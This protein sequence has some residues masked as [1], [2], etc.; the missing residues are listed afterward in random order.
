MPA[1][2]NNASQKAAGLYVAFFNRKPDASG[3]E[4]WS[5]KFGEGTGVEEAADRFADSEE[6]QA[7][8]EFLSEHLNGDD[9][10]FSEE[11]AGD[12]IDQIYQNLFGRDPDD[13]GREFWINELQSGTPVGQIV[14]QV[15][16]GAQ[17]EDADLID[18][19]VETRLQAVEG[20]RNA[21]IT[22]E[23]DNGDNT[24][25]GTDRDDELSGGAG[26]D[27]LRGGAG[28]DTL[29]GGVGDDVLNGGPGDD[30]LTGGA[31]ADDFVFD[32]AETDD[33]DATGDDSDSDADDE[34]GDE[35]GTDTSDAMGPP[36]GKGPPSNA[37]PN[38][39]DGGAED[40]EG[41]GDV[42]QAGNGPDNVEGTE[43]ADYISGG[44][45][46]DQLY[47][48]AGDD[49]IKGG[50]GPDTLVGGQGNDTMSGGLGPDRF[51]FDSEDTG[52]DTVTDFFA[53]T[54]TLVFD[55]P[56]DDTQDDTETQTRVTESTIT[57]TGVEGTIA[58]GDTVSITVGGESATVT[59]SG[60][61][62]AIGVASAIASGL[63]E[64]ANVESASAD[65]QTVTLTATSDGDVDVTEFVDNTAATVTADTE[66]VAETEVTEEEAG[67][68]ETATDGLEAPLT[69]Q[70]ETDDDEDKAIAEGDTVSM[71][72]T[73][74]DDPEG[75]TLTA[76]LAGDED[77]AG[78]AS[79][80][81]TVLA[82]D[83][84]VAEASVGDG[85][86]ITVTPVDGETVDLTEF[87]SETDEDVNIEADI[88]GVDDDDSDDAGDD[89]AGDDA[90]G[91]DTQEDA[92]DDS[93]LDLPESVSIAEED[94]NV[95]VTHAG[96]TVTLENVSRDELGNGNFKFAGAEGDGDT[97]IGDDIITDFSME[98]GDMIKLN[99]GDGD[100][101]VTMADLSVEAY[102]NDAGETV[103]VTL[104]TTEG[105]ITIIGDVTTGTKLSDYVS[106][107]G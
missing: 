87:T 90:A 55:A 81:A 75:T 91:D 42:I 66:S 23:G 34:S 32:L 29:N 61:Q 10:N 36:E 106:F 86:T 2:L 72:L 51:R 99:A 93:G 19:Q 6:A 11:E 96:G 85:S 88:D 107:E 84:A 26:S 82:E 39:G 37:G 45:G 12:A 8:F 69:I 102:E 56:S 68:S 20:D 100:D 35:S 101:A 92:D 80:L 27:T 48:L 63:G 62:D 17:N 30:E 25:E 43:N 70:I 64:L 4:F 67:G 1:N 57:I 14:V 53:P 44:N 83:D 105:E 38:N 13:A 33:Q 89:D 77:A 95:V 5:K 49:T 94:G 60:D 74:A 97:D 52:D 59:F 103:G 50:N 65:S 24:L 54:D 40:F 28:D 7:R 98:D 78:I 21:G 9:D 18:S 73:T 3:L 31:G 15:L 58:D 46:P 47:G 16:F 104:D 22:E 41:D 76:T 71:T 79:A